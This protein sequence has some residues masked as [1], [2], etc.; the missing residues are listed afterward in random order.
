MPIED[1]R[2]RFEELSTHPLPHNVQVP[3]RIL[4]ETWT[5]ATVTQAVAD[6]RLPKVALDVAQCGA[7]KS[8]KL[9]IYMYGWATGNVTITSNKEVR[10]QIRT[11]VEANRRDDQERGPAIWRIDVTRNL[12]AKSATPPPAL[13]M[14]NGLGGHALKWQR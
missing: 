12:L 8:S 3:I 7:F 2:R 9:S 10:G 5:M 4:A 6:K 1:I 14:E 13:R 11:W